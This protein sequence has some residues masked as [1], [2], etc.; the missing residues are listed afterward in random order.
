TACHKEAPLPDFGVLP[1][2]NL[3][4]QADRPFGLEDLRGKTWIANFMFTSCTTFCPVLTAQMAEL[5]KKLG[6]ENQRLHFVSFTVD[7]VR[8]SPHALSEYARRMKVA[9]ENWTFLTGPSG[10][11]RDVITKGFHIALGARVPSS[12]GTYDIL[13]SRHFVLVDPV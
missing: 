12:K 6:N 13:H 9:H 2:F 8:D 1:D 11:V 4:D 3:R 5:R 7:P 10:E